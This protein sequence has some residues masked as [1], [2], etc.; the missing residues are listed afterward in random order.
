SLG[1]GLVVLEGVLG[2]FRCSQVGFGAVQSGLSSRTLF[3]RCSFRQIIQ[4]CLSLCHLLG[5]FCPFLL[6]GA[7]ILCEGIGIVCFNSGFSLCQLFL[8]PL[9]FGSVI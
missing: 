6:Q 7:F 9:Q 4:C 8:C 3:V 5:S 1:D 2:F